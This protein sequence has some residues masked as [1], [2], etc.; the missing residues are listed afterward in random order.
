MRRLLPE[1]PVYRHGEKGAGSP[2]PNCGQSE[3]NTRSR[4]TSGVPGLISIGLAVTRNGNEFLPVR[5][6]EVPMTRRYSLFAASRIS[7]PLNCQTRRRVRTHSSRRNAQTF[8][9]WVRSHLFV[10]FLNCSRCTYNVRHQR[11]CLPYTQA[12]ESNVVKHT[13]TW[14]PYVQPFMFH[15]HCERSHHLWSGTRPVLKRTGDCALTRLQA[16]I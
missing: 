7:F 4:R 14:L 16:N 1:L 15:Y 8:R 3:N 6:T 12:L 5:R 11:R 10:R 13:N 2:R 9:E